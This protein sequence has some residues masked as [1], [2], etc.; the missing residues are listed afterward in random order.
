MRLGVLS[1]AFPS[2]SLESVAAWA[3]GAGFESIEVA[4]WPAE[5]DEARRYG[6]VSH[7]DVDN[8]RPDE[9][10]ELLERHGLEISALAYYPNNL[11]PDAE[12]RERVHAHLRKVIEAAARL[13][14]P[15]VGTFI[16]NDQHKTTAE[17]LR[18]FGEIWPA[19]VAFA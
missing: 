1:A 19:L 7:I 9:I 13:G 17:N 2:D 6:G 8:V 10:A 15:T 3:A 5:E 4:C 14:V 11:H 16:G 12:H 18:R